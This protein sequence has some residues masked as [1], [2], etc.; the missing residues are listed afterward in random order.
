MTGGAADGTR[1]GPPLELGLC[2]AQTMSWPETAERWRQIEDFGFDSAWLFDHFMSTSGGSD[3]TYLEA[4]TAL[5]GLAAGTSRVQLG[6]LVTGNTYRSPVL[7]AKEAVTVD[8]ISNG[9]LILG[10]GAGWH[11]PEHRAYGFPFPPPGERVARFRESVQVIKALLGQERATY[12]GRYYQLQDAP[13]EPKPVRPSGIPLVVGTRGAR[14]LRLVAEYADRWNMVGSPDEI[15]ERGKLL[16]DACAQVGRDP[17]EIRWSA[18]TWSKSL[19]FDPLSSPEAYR[20][21]VGRYQEVGV[22]EVLCAW[23]PDTAPASI[24]RIAAA[25]PALRESGSRAVG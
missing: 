23:G 1:T 21:L 11:E 18:A 16:L 4:W 7:L 25:L 14:M 13:F 22:S 2:T 20:D 10:L 12:A 8:Q 9:R 17:A 3:H 24:E 19:A 5:A 15:R 6:V